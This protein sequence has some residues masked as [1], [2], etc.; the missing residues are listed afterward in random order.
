M[1][2]P[3]SSVIPKA[4]AA[5]DSHKK[6]GK[7]DKNLKKISAACMAILQYEMEACQNP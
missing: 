7:S 6:T 5:S 4:P 2:K 1:K 3:K